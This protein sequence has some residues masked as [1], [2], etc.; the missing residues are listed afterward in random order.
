[1]SGTLAVLIGAGAA[2]ASGAAT[3]LL[4][5]SRDRR[6]RS[7]Q[8]Y[9]VTGLER[10]DLKNDAARMSEYKVYERLREYEEK[11]AK[12]L[13]N[14]YL[15]ISGG[16]TTELDAVM[17]CSRGIFVFESKSRYGWLEGSETDRE[18]SQFLFRKDG[19][20]IENKLYNPILQNRGHIAHLKKLLGGR[21]RT[22]SVISFSENTDIERINVSDP[23]TFVTHESKLPIIVG[24]I[25]WNAKDTLT[26]KDIT[27][28][29]FK[30]YPYMY[31]TDEQK[32]KH[33]NDIKHKYIYGK[34]KG[35]RKTRKKK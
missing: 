30:L 10:K 5:S 18:W 11:G 19:S 34:G 33:I 16:R 28:I 29:Y 9:R 17:I 2:L 12:F 14:L 21:I 15:P 26:E 4:I 13:F 8:Y 32:E 31:V 7:G 35:K 27:S 6:Y 22:W 3:F 1:M 23:D 25:Y 24:N 20:L